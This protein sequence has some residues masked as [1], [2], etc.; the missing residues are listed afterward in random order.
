ML[1]SGNKSWLCS[2]LKCRNEN[3]NASSALLV[4][5]DNI[6][7]NCEMTVLVSH[8]ALAQTKLFVTN[9]SND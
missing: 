4:T 7:P 3:D 6:L 5:A 2:K 8:S 1:K 9:P